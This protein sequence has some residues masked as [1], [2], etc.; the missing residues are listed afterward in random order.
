M[1]SLE[2]MAVLDSAVSYGSVIDGTKRCHIA[3]TGVRVKSL[4]VHPLAESLDY[5]WRKALH[6][7]I[8]A[9]KILAECRLCRSTV[10]S[11]TWA[12]AGLTAFGTQAFG[13]Q[14]SPHL[15][16]LNRS[17]MRRGFTNP[18]LPYMPDSKI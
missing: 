3:R 12:D 7:R 10:V 5:L 14:I 13:K 9:T 1:Y 15:P 8:L 18:L 16:A 2:R 6:I 11:R 4:E 17:V